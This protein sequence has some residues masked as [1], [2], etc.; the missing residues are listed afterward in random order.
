MQRCYPASELFRKEKSPCFTSLARYSSQKVCAA[1]RNS[2]NQPRCDVTNQNIY[3]ES[4]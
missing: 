3:L 4:I 2:G 1:R